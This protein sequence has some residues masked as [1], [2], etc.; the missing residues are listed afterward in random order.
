MM[1]YLN[2]RNL[3]LPF[4]VMLLLSSCAKN[5]SESQQDNEL[6]ILN[7]TQQVYFPNAVPMNGDGSLWLISHSRTGTGDRVDSGNHVAIDYTGRVLPG[8]GGQI[9][10]TT[11]ANTAR[12]LGTFARN[13]HFAPIFTPT[14]PMQV[15]LHTALSEMRVGDTV[16]MMSASWLAF[17]AQSFERWHGEVSL[18]A[19]T[20]IVFEVVLH[21]IAPNPSER[22][23]NIVKNYVDSVNELHP[24]FFVQAQDHEGNPL[25]GFYISYA[26]TVPLHDTASYA[27][28]GSRMEV[29]YA[30]FYVQTGFLLDSNIDSITQRGWG[31]APA[32]T[33]DFTFTFTSTGESSEAI[34]AMSLALRN[35]APGSWVEAVFTS[36]YG[37]G[38]NGYLR[39]ATNQRITDRPIHPY[40]PLR[41]K[42]FFVG[43]STD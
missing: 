43:H 32:S 9:F 14:E 16:K 41:F 11:D 13:A 42:I 15:A 33:N 5:P 21:E 22:E 31:M 18:P 20:P 7:A 37:Y 25:P 3:V 19:N 39:A 27:V 36:D 2:C 1:K 35:V 4:A 40:T 29:K 28:E 17:G 30:G 24:A 6:R 38:A 8:M 10:Q 26:N 34:N 23:L 12:Q